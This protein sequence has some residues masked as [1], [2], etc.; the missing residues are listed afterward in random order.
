MSPLLQLSYWFDQ[1]PVRLSP[2]FEY[3]FFFLFAVLAIGAA[4]LRIASKRSTRDS[5]DKK[6]FLMAGNMLGWLS[7]FGFLW[8]FTSYEEVQFFGMRA[9]FL[10]WVIAFVICA[11]RVYRFVKVE[12]PELR[13]R[14][15]SQADAN[16]YLPRRAR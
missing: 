14:R 2:V 11:Y 5:L 15:Q 12:A 3:G 9:W 10:L 13:E 16:K 8:L 1:S 7:A 4:L 6:A